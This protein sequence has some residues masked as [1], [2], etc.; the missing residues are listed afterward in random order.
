MP[1]QEQEYSKRLDLAVWKRLLQFA[2]PYR[3]SLF[4]LISQ[5][6]LL[7]LVDAL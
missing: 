3:K 7:G 4:F 2:R 1:I 5:M 6:V